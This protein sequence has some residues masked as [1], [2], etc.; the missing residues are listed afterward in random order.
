MLQ[1][2]R[3]EIQEGE[4]QE[5][6]GNPRRKRFR[7]V[8]KDENVT[9]TVTIKGARGKCTCNIDRNDSSWCKHLYMYQRLKQ[10]LLGEAIEKQM[11]LF[12]DNSEDYPSDVSDS[13]SEDYE[14][15]QILN[16]IM[17]MILEMIM[18]MMMVIRTNQTIMLVILIIVMNLISQDMK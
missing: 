1:F 3:R 8:F 18:E 13:E 7:K 4:T 17:E 14:S 16:L 9:Y 5:E 12:A 6:K 11:N 15:F 10:L 2:K